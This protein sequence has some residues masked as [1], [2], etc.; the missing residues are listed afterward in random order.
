[1]E[2]GGEGAQLSAEACPNNWLPKTLQSVWLHTKIT[3][4]CPAMVACCYSNHGPQYKKLDGVG[5]VDNRPS[6]D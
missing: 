4:L 6:T 3:E 1:M 2:N 5:P